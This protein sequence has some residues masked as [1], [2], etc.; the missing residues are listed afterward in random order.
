M[1]KLLL[2]PNNNIKVDGKS[3]YTLYLQLK[4]HFNGRGDVIKTNWTM[5]V[6]DA[7]YQKRK[8]KFFFERLSGK[9]TLKELCLIFIGNLMAN[10]SMWVGEIS[11]GDAISFYKT[12]IARLKRMNI[13]YEEDIKNIYYVAKKLGL[14]ALKEIFQY[15]TEKNSSIIFKMLQAGQISFE[16]F[17]MLDT[18]LN[19]I[20]SHDAHDD[21]IW[22][23]YS[24]RL[25]AYRKI[26][27][28]DKTHCTEVFKSVIQSSKY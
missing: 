14:S 22:S 26:L 10:E 16:T 5:K 15:N 24:V 17:L 9:F 8:D 25:K 11:D 1:A 2:P 3:V 6:S 28:L 4:N 12:Y 18:F 13:R 7:S 20:D 27:V 23:K 21:I 19:I